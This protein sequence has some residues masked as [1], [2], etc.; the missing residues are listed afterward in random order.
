MNNCYILNPI[1]LEILNL[2]TDA[3]DNNI[4]IVFIASATPGYI[5]NILKKT[6]SEKDLTSKD[7]SQLKDFYGGKYR[8]KLGWAVGEGEGE[9]GNDNGNDREGVV[10]AIQSSDKT[11]GCCEEFIGGEGS[12]YDMVITEEELL[13]PAAT[14]KVSIADMRAENK[15]KKLKAT[16]GP[17]FNFDISIFPEDNIFTIKEKIFVATGIPVYR[18][19]L[20]WRGG[21]FQ[22]RETSYTLFTDAGQRTI[23]IISSFKNCGKNNDTGEIPI[24]TVLYNNRESI[25]VECM[26]YFKLIA[27]CHISDPSRGYLLRLVDMSQF[28]DKL[29]S[30]LDQYRFDLYYYGF[31]VKFW[32]MITL[33]IFST[34]LED[35]AE[36]ANKYPEMSRNAADLTN[37]FLRE[38]KILNTNYGAAG[39]VMK[40]VKS[41]KIK[42]SIISLIGTVAPIAPTTLSLRNLFDYLNVTRCFPE[43]HC[44]T[45]FDGYYYHLRKVNIQNKSNV[46]FPPEFKSGFIFAVS[47]RKMDQDNFHSRE[48]KMTLEKE[49]TRYLF[50]NILENGY[51]NVKSVWNEEEERSFDEI[52]GLM[53]R[54]INP[55]INMINEAGPYIFSS[56]SLA[57]IH[58]KSIII[59]SVAAG[60]IWNKFINEQSFKMLTTSMDEYIR[61][62]IVENRT[63]VSSGRVNNKFDFLFKKGM[64]NYSPAAVENNLIGPLLALLQNQYSHL[65]VNAAWQRWKQFYNGRMMTITHRTSDIK[66]EI[67]GVNTEELNLFVRYIQVFIS[68]FMCALSDSSSATAKI[69]DI[70]GRDVKKIKKLKEVDPEL[71]N[72]K[73]YGYK[74]AY[75]VICQNPKQPVVYTDD[76]IAHM[77]KAEIAG[78]YQYWNF[79]TGKEAFYSCPSKKYPHLFFITGVHPKNYCLPCCKKSAGFKDINNKTAAIASICAKKHYFDKNTDL[80][81]FSDAGKHRHIINYGRSLDEGRVARLPNELVNTLFQEQDNLLYVIYGVKQSLPAYPSGDLGLIFSLAECL[82]MSVA[83][84]AK[85]VLDTLKNHPKILSSIAGGGIIE[86]Y[87]STTNNLFYLIDKI[88]IQQEVVMASSM[89]G[90]LV[91]N[92]LAKDWCNLFIEIAVYRLGTYIIVFEDKTLLKS[93]TD[94]G[95]SSKE[96]IFNVLVDKRL[97]VSKEQIAAMRPGTKII[98]IVNK[99]PNYYPIF[100]IDDR[101]YY[102]NK[103]PKARHFSHKSHIFTTIMDEVKNN[104]RMDNRDREITF[105]VLISFM[106]AQSKE[107]Y[108]ISGKFINLHGF[109][110]A[111]KI[112]V[113]NTNSKAGEEFVMAL[114]EAPYRSDSYCIIFTPF[115]ESDLSGDVTAETLTTF[116][117][118]FN[119]WAKA[120]GFNQIIFKEIIV[121]GSGR[122]NSSFINSEEGLWPLPKEV[123]NMGEKIPTRNVTFNANKVNDDIYH[124]RISHD[125]QNTA[126]TDNRSKNW[127]NRVSAS[128]YKNYLYQLFIIQFINEMHNKN[129]NLSIRSKIKGVFCKDRM[130][131]SNIFEDLQEIEGVTR[132]DA[133]RISSLLSD[134]S[135]GVG[136][137]ELFD[138]IDNATWDFDREILNKL[139]AAPTNEAI[140]AVV[141]K[142]TFIDEKVEEKL[143]KS[144]S[145][146][147][148]VLT[149][150][151]ADSGICAGGKLI[152]PSEEVRQN[153]INLL[154][155][156]LK[157]PLK[158][159]I[160]MLGNIS[161]NIIN[162][163]D[164]NAN[165]YEKIYIEEI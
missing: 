58:P 23:D 122:G 146:F 11:G 135:G 70:I 6:T 78:L 159:K 114:H 31:V 151:N 63:I 12:D 89:K 130:K 41:L 141:N 8:Q 117:S 126:D 10:S 148:N 137:K 101:D 69:G 110:Y 145:A 67:L 5:I 100:F 140:T 88:F 62:G 106:K 44:Y 36:I 80:T 93:E 9:Y 60:I 21:G 96:A 84:L 64:Y 59:K 37:K 57:A 45:T 116:Q 25:K 77:S 109:C 86:K 158:I 161:R 97:P 121:S 105:D 61:A 81:E 71:Y 18:Q 1:K 48:S 42:T 50:L 85:G 72:L 132:R 112:K 127:R 103:V 90:L 32:P 99:G 7:K 87:F 35:E 162:F 51:Y 76:E 115:K 22:D 156:D 139:I 34:F 123:V 111:A 38:A 147:P 124:W 95:A 28:F 165:Q 26:D 155:A 24:D 157:N 82:E 149:A 15:V 40:M 79:T 47:L 43:S 102:K 66:F 154:A 74:R 73:K 152:L 52:I 55:V 153:F 29:N 16:F 142:F 49:Q 17:Q 108:V 107:K 14:T 164:F 46:Q 160:L 27:H 131:M 138:L 2:K 33:E 143:S 39:Q 94:E 83:T 98:F 133:L 104:Q 150:C 118:D 20:F 56:G 120:A 92:F 19:H 4:L 53:Q 65:S 119:K 134:R 128:L 54:F 68:K 144:D 163:F 91:K 30:K 125:K 75:S 136:T 3:K 13:K 129:K 113:P